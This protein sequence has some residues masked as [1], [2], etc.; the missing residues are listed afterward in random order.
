ME[1]WALDKLRLARFYVVTQYLSFSVYD[2]PVRHANLRIKSPSNSNTY[3][4]FCT[5]THGRNLCLN[6]SIASNGHDPRILPPLSCRIEMQYMSDIERERSRSFGSR[7][8]VICDKNIWFKNS[9]F[10][11]SLC[12]D[13][14]RS[15]F[16]SNTAPCALSST[17]SWCQ[18]ARCVRHCRRNRSLLVLETAPFITKCMI[19]ELLPFIIMHW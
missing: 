1:E 17:K 12:I 9:C 7:N 5:S 2:L 13:R 14:K 19:Q 18:S 8:G 3:L 11:L 6:F 10:R 15:S 16:N 4:H